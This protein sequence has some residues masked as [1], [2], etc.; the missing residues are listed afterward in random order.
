MLKNV[1]VDVEAVRDG[2]TNREWINDQHVVNSVN[3]SS[4]SSLSQGSFLA[5]GNES[6]MRLAMFWHVPRNEKKEKIK[7]RKTEAIKIDF[8]RRPTI[9]RVTKY[10]KLSLNVWMMD[11]FNS[12]ARFSAPFTTFF[13]Q[14]LVFGG[15][16]NGRSSIF[17]VIIAFECMVRNKKQGGSPAYYTHMVKVV[18]PKCFLRRLQEFFFNFWLLLFKNSG[19]KVW[20]K[21]QKKKEQFPLIFIKL[22]WNSPK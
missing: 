16:R 5:F 6:V 13:T 12:S 9:Y 10:G 1:D 4:P 11:E 15:Q 7:P 19:K 18:T 22:N 2:E 14:F 8:R 20:K 21:K 17:I 3:G